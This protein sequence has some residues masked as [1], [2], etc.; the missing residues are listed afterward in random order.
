MVKKDTICWTC[1]WAGGKDKKCPWASEFK[2]VPGWDA[3]PTKLYNRQEIVNGK[4]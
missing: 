4:Q 3:T 2:P 1:E